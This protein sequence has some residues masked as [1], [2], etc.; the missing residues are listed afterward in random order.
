MNVPLTN[1]L[2]SKWVHPINMIKQRSDNFDTKLYVTSTSPEPSSKIDTNDIILKLV[3]LFAI[4]VSIF[5]YGENIKL[6]STNLAYQTINSLSSQLSEKFDKQS[7]AFDE[8]FDK[9]LKVIDEKFDKQSK[10][11]DELK[12]AKTGV[13]AIFTVATASGTITSVV[14]FFKKNETKSV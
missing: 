14:Q 10:S 12:D 6:S 13:I 3:P 11:L 2:S 1:K 7:K 5:L 9:Q 4:L 8:K